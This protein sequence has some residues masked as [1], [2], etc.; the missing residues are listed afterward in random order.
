MYKYQRKTRDTWQLW[1][2]YGQGWEHE[3][4]EFTLRDALARKDEYRANCPQY[5]VKV[6]CKRE[7][8][9]GV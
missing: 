6:R 5:P 7:R 2:N 4:T 9:E 3:C 1:V 8:L